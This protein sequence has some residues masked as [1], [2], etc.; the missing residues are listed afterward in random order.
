MSKTRRIVDRISRDN[1]RLELLKKLVHAKEKPMRRDQVMGIL[2]LS[3]YYLAQID[4]RFADEGFFSRANDGIHRWGWGSYRRL[5]KDDITSQKLIPPKENALIH[6]LIYY[7]RAGLVNEEDTNY[8]NVKRLFSPLLKAQ[9]GP[10][11]GTIELNVNGIPNMVTTDF[12]ET[13]KTNIRYDAVINMIKGD[14]YVLL[15]WRRLEIAVDVAYRLLKDPRIRLAVFSDEAFQ[16]DV[17]AQRD[18]DLEARMGLDVNNRYVK[19]GGLY[20]IKSVPSTQAK[21]L[22]EA[23]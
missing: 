1:H 10:L 23:C 11:D 14:S 7:V 12:Y 13:D 9:L 6:L 4:K 5:S 16:R 17:M 15:D 18:L 21:A 3:Y 8:T 22:S 19:V 2:G 20:L